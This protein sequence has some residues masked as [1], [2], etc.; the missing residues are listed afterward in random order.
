MGRATGNEITMTLNYKRHRF[1]ADACLA[2]AFIPRTGHSAWHRVGAQRICLET[3]NKHQ[4]RDSGERDKVWVC[5]SAHCFS[6][7]GMLRLF[8]DTT[9]NVLL[10]ILKPPSIRLSR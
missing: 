1:R 2:H 10:G 6:L 9:I 4:H 7:G 3:T 5:P 8:P